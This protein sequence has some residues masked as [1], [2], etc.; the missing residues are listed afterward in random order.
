MSE[1]FEQKPPIELEQEA[2]SW[3]SAVYE[4]WERGLAESHEAKLVGKLID[5]LCGRQWSQKARYGLALRPR[6]S[7]YLRVSSDGKV[8]ISKNVGLEESC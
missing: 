3:T 1:R 4:E 7:R 8:S 2:L 5:F 6:V